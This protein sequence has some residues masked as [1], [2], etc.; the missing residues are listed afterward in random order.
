MMFR[1]VLIISILLGLLAAGSV[2]GQDAPAIR[3]GAVPGAVPVSSELPPKSVFYYDAQ[4]RPVAT[5]EKAEHREEM[6]YRD[7]I[8]GNLRIYYPSG[9]L[10]RLVSYLH[11]GRGLKYGTETSF[12]E[13]GEVKSRCPY[14]VEQT[15][16]YEQFFRNGQLRF[17]QSFGVAPDG[18]A[19]PGAAFASDGKPV[20]EGRRATEK[21]PALRGAG[22]L[23]SDNSAIVEAVMRQLRYPAEALRAQVTGRVFVSFMVDDTGFVRDAHI[24]RSPSPLLNAA[25]LKAVASLARFTPGEVDGDTADVFYTI[26][27]TFSIQ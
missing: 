10:R 8:G 7:S 16:P 21:M 26:P 20:P 15:G 4:G 5:A 12:Y 23:G 19:L 11:F 17:R 24:L 9:N 3:T 1:L 6:V 22:R 27:I 2:L 13:T 14:K 18:H 25:A